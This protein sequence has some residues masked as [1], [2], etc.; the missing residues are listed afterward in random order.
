MLH[1]IVMLPKENVIFKFNSLPAEKRLDGIS[2]ELYA[3]N[4]QK[5]KL[6]LFFIMK[7]EKS[8]FFLLA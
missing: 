3:N 1:S 4:L 2:S 8:L 7:K 6:Q 5:E